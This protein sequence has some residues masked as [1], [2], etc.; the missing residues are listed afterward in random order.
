[1]QRLMQKRVGMILSGKQRLHAMVAGWKRIRG[2]LSANDT[3][4]ATQ[5]A[6][7]RRVHVFW[8]GLVLAIATFILLWPALLNRHPVLAP[9][10]LDYIKQG[11]I[12]L[13]NL[14]IPRSP[15]TDQMTALQRFT[16]WCFYLCT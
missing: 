11:R 10:S 8:F 7:R 3:Y 6:R 15:I 14:R 5:N 12:I 13:H 16:A 1:M 4:L 2:R 9:D